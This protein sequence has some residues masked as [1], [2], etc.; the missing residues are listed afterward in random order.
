[1]NYIPDKK[2]ISVPN[3][4]QWL[5][6]MGAGSWFVIIEAN[7]SYSITRYS[8]LGDLE[9]CGNFICTPIGLDL[10]Q[11]FKFTYLSHCTLCT[12]I[13]NEITYIFSILKS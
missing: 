6:G 4:A 5:G 13:Q 11:E 10:N 9:C 8:K 12:I 7:N 1:M 2:P 3:N